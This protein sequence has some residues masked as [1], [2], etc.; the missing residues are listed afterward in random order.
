M[1]RFS[2]VSGR[3]LERGGGFGGLCGGPGPRT[4]F[5]DEFGRFWGAFGTPWGT[6]GTPGGPHG[7]HFATVGVTFERL[8]CRLRAEP[9]FSLRLVPETVRKSGFSRTADVAKT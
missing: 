9:G 2:V 7:R 8:F 4:A 3:F 5:F 6:L 1:H